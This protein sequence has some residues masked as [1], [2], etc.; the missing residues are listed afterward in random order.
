MAKDASFDIVSE[1]KRDEVNNAIQQTKKELQQR[2]DFKGTGASIDWG[3]ELTIEAGARAAGADID[4]GAVG[5]AARNA[6]RAG[7]GS[8]FAVA[9][10]VRGSFARADAVVTNLPW[11]RAAALRGRPATVWRALGEAAERMVVLAEQDARGDFELADTLSVM[12]AHPTL[13]ATAVPA[14]IAPWRARAAAAGLV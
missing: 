1:V 2:Y 14:L 13:Y 6:A 9:D 12:G 11:G 7:V 8:R 4:E 3:E 10:V 5:M